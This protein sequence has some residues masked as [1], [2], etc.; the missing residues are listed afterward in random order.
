MKPVER[1]A[2]HGTKSIEGVECDSFGPYDSKVYDLQGRPV[3]SN[4]QGF[5]IKKGKKYGRMANK[6]AK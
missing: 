4:Q 3:D 6:I 5:C 2:L 1:L